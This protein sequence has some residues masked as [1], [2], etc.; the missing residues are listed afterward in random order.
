M[1][2]NRI[3]KVKW[4]LNRWDKLEE[5]KIIHYQHLNLEANIHFDKIISEKTVLFSKASKKRNQFQKKALY[6][7]NKTLSYPKIES[8]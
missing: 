7:K 1:S 6:I 8:D 5:G 2:N 4:Q 3:F